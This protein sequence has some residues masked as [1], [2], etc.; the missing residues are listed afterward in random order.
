VAAGL[1]DGA[2]QVDRAQIFAKLQKWDEAAQAY[3]RAITAE[4]KN[5]QLWLERGRIY[6]RMEKWDQ[7][8]ADFTKAI[9]LLPEARSVNDR[10]SEICAELAQWDQAM[11]KAVQLMPKGSDLYIAAGRYHARLSQWDKA[12]ADFARADWS[13]PLGDD[14]FEYAC[15][16]LIRGDAEGYRKFCDGLITRIGSSKD[17]FAAFVLARIMGMAPP[18]VLDPARA[19]QWGKLAVDADPKVPW[20][21]HAL[22]L[23]HYRAGQFDLA[24]QR[25]QES[26][27][28]YWNFPEL[29][30]LG[31]ALA[32]HHLGHA[33]A[34]RENFD[35]GLAWLQKHTPTKSDWPTDL[36]A[37][38]W[39][40]AQL[41]RREAEALMKPG[42]LGSPFR[43]HALYGN[44]SAST[45]FAVSN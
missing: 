39:L 5:H 19:L 10:R 37:T 38:D 23:A 14:T 6:A 26:L 43:G 34:A 24:L 30:Y 42:K 41:L 21:L 4:T 35:Q 9:E 17:P 7:V 44:H 22:A 25:F 3:G 31:R 33:A 12:A 29:N 32:E 28:G 2:T 16:F 15:L 27:D 36:F 8:A 13:R 20:Y 11:T 45:L 40:E 18:G 1:D